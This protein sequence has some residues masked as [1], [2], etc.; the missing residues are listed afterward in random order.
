MS[1]WIN[2]QIDPALE[3][4]LRKAICTANIPTLLMVLVQLTGDKAW[5]SAPYMPSRA[6][7]LDD[8]DSGGLPEDIQGEIRMVAADAIIDWK[9][10]KPVAIPDPSAD[11]LTHMISVS[12]GEK[13]PEN[14]GEIIAAELSPS[15]PQK[16]ARTFSGQVPEDFKAII[17]GGGV[18]GIC[19]GIRLQEYAIDFT[20]IEKNA[21]F[22]GTWKDNKYPAAGVDTPNHLY[23]FSFAPNDW[24]RYFSLRGEIIGYIEAVAL[25]YELSKNTHFETT[26]VD[27][28]FETGSKKWH[29]RTRGPNGQQETLIGNVILSA[30]GL[31]SVPFV[32]DIA[33][34]DTFTGK[35]C[36]TAQWPSDLDLTGKKVA[37]VGN[38]ASAMQV[39]PAIV[40]KV[41]SLTIFAR[42]KQWAAPFPQFQQQVPEHIRF[43]LKEVP[44]YQGWYRQRLAWT[45]NDRLHGALQR[46]PEWPDKARSI[47]ATN[48]R[49]RKIFL[50]YIENELGDRQ[51]LL[52]DLVPDYPPYGKRIL[53]DNG[54]YRTV[55]KPHVKLV[56]ERLKEVKGDTLVADSGKSFD[57]DVLIM[58]TGFK[59]TEILSSLDVIGSHGQHL[60]DAWDTD[61]PKAY[62][63]TLVPDFPNMFVLLGPNTGLGHGGS[64]I[65]VVERQINY[66]LLL[67]EKMFENHSSTIEVRRNIFEDYNEKVDSAHA[68][69]I[70]THEGTTNWYRNK[71]GRVVAITPWRNDD[72]WRM[73]RKINAK[74]YIFEGDACATKSS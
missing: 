33:G 19:A 29:V 15:V 47:N 31:L 14:Y 69:M 66:V 17:I 26:V 5:L 50:N 41:K 59:S 8:N 7:G 34:L 11:L 71:R 2:T 44:L 30:V 58:A 42:S 9:K 32:P 63:G 27:A 3:V 23:S 38:G 72:F 56:P 51:D 48:D 39:A 28:K 54:W 45:F 62:M 37:I 25:D 64:I 21:G 24:S 18:S 4:R 73:T 55:A 60:K 12:T 49:H 68:K 52:E 61:N 1:D 74:D 70:W 53:L 10:G 67:L 6:R 40:D 13:V 35:T 43:L 20:I 22:G 36:H 65:P 57:A 46:D 16:N